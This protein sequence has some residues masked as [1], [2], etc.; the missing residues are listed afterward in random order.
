MSAGDLLY[1]R[2][3]VQGTFSVWDRPNQGVASG[4]EVLFALHAKDKPVAIFLGKTFLDNEIGVCWYWVL[5]P[6]G[7]G[8]M[9]ATCFE[10]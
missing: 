5:T 1:C 4:A 8:W 10:S 7:V 9:R 3:G 2:V 6:N